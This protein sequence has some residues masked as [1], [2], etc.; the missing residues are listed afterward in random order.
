ML[1]VV[2]EVRIFPQLALDEWLSPHPV[3]S[4]IFFRAIVTISSFRVFVTSFN[5][6]GRWDPICRFFAEA[7]R[8]GDFIPAFTVYSYCH[9]I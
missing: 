8:P 7:E 2:I 9:S 5:E 4:E 3:W 1:R 6:A